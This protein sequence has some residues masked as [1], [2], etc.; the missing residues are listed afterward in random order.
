[1][2]SWV[3]IKV[4]DCIDRS[5]TLNEF[6]KQKNWKAQVKLL[7]TSTSFPYWKVAKSAALT[8]WLYIDQHEKL[9]RFLT[10]LVHPDSDPSFVICFL[11]N[12]MRHLLPHKTDETSRLSSLNFVGKAGIV[13][14]KII[15]KR[16]LKDNKCNLVHNIIWNNEIPSSQVECFLISGLD[17][18]WM[19][20]NVYCAGP[21]ELNRANIPRQCR[22]S[23]DHLSFIFY[24]D[25]VSLLV[26]NF[27][28]LVSSRLSWPWNSAFG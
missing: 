20:F 13:C 10:E 21:T 24:I 1:M 15:R 23:G 27:G 2:I 17:S 18:L 4:V 3:L 5:W 25:R 28:M 14:L 26:S 9:Q 6:E 22:L 19:L 7:C 11:T 8:C 12:Q 16:F